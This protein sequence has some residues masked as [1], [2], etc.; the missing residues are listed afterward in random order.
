[1][2]REEGE[3]TEGGVP[4]RSDGSGEQLTQ[5]ELDTL[6]ERLALLEGPKRQEIVEAIATARGFGDLSE[7]FEYHAAKNEQGLNEREIT[8]L[9]ERV[10]NAVV[11]EAATSEVIGIGSQVEVEDDLGERMTVRVSSVGG[12]GAVSP[13]SPL[14]RALMGAKAG[15]K[16]TVRAPRTTY[17]AHV[18]SVS[19]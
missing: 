19:W 18:V 13:D 10:R 8:I 4:R 12:E 16:V 11:V 2:A 9:R 14:G 1:M 17:V 7:N 5:A 6:K 15:D 3:T